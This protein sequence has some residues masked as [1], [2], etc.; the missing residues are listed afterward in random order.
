MD[1]APAITTPIPA[2]KKTTKSKASAKPK[3]PAAHPTYEEM[4]VSAISALADKRGSSRIA[5]KKY[6]FVT[7]NILETKATN[8]RINTT[9]KKTVDKGLTKTNHFHAGLFKKVKPENPK[10][11]AVKPK[12]SKTAKVAK[13]LSKK[14]AQKSPLMKTS[15]LA[16]K[17]T[18]KKVAAKKTL[19][20]A[21][22]KKIQKA[23][24]KKVKKATPKK[25]KKAASKKTVAKKPAVKKPVAKVT[26]PTKK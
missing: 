20:K 24:P 2:T 8:S 9:L 22:Q 19:K 6:I 11:A 7:Y 17:K 10:A 14:V 1:S 4:I 12:V 15:K 26:K 18:P 25:I 23:T 5:I 16:T 3:A 21:T 13:K